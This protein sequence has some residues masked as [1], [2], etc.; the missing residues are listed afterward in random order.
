MKMNLKTVATN[1]EESLSGRR[2]L[3]VGGRGFIGRHVVNALLDAG[4]VVTA[5]ALS[6]P[7]EIGK[8]GGVEHMTA[9]FRDPDSLGRTLAGRKFDYVV[10]AGGYIDH[11][12]YFSGGRSLIDQHFVATMNLLDLVKGLELKG[13]VQI[14]SSDEYG[15]MEAPQKE[16]TREMPIAPY[17]LAKV[18]S[19]HLVQMLYRTEGLPGVIVR[20][21]LVY[22]P[23]Q[24]HHRFLPQVILGCLA[25]EI[26]ETSAGMQLRDFCYIEDFVSAI[27]LAMTK[28]EAH[29]KVFNIAS[30]QPISIRE[31]IEKVVS[32][33]G[34]GKP[35]FAKIPY[36]AGENMTLYAD[37]SLAKEILGWHPVTPLDEGLRKTIAWYQ[38]AG[39]I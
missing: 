4:G 15:S 9:D 1:L 34:G 17:S 38:Q 21:F 25:D 2:A 39:E 36:R 16:N 23:G 28:K 14:G 30:G 20:G 37:T 22:G 26:F 8:R 10:N 29:G 24:D 27:L 35:D 18:A 5:L 32:M 19:N 3:V 13:Y 33:V 31:V 6:V 7:P 12:P 11:R